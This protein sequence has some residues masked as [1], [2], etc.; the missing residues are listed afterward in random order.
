MLCGFKS[1]HTRTIQVALIPAQV[2]RNDHQGV[3]VYVAPSKALVNQV[4]RDD[5]HVELGIL[6]PMGIIIGYTMGYPVMPN[7]LLLKMAQLG[8]NIPYMEHMGW[9]I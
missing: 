9:D 5:S 2:L 3:A 4:G 7:S 8:V 1:I 6:P